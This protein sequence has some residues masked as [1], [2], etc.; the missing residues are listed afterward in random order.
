MTAWFS[1]PRNKEAFYKAQAQKAERQSIELARAG[2]KSESD[3][4]KDVA[5][6]A[7][8]AAQAQRELIDDSTK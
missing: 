1:N 4:Y 2:N 5:L 6:K 7:R 3:R 8:E